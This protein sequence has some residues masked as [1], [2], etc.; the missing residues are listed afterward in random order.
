MF[1]YCQSHNVIYLQDTETIINGK[2]FYGTPWTPSFNNWSF[3]KDD[4]ILN[5]YWDNIPDDVDVLIT[6]GPAFGIADEVEEVKEGKINVGSKSLLKKIETLKTLNLEYHL[7]GHIHECYGYCNVENYT[8]INASLLTSKTSKTS[9][10]LNVPI[11]FE[12]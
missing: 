8:A 12:I 4:D 2:K 3:M 5:R 11:S 9:N 1:S 7:F 6:H 10:T